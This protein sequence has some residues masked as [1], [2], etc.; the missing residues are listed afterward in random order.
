MTIPLALQPEI[1]KGLLAQVTA[2]GI[3]LAIRARDCRSPGAGF[4]R[5]VDS[6]RYRSGLIDACARV[7]GLLTA[8]Q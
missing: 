3:S 4:L 6:A 5:T 1:E 7:R 8:D 2:R